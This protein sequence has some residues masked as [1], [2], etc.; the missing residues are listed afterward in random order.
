MRAFTAAAI[1][2][3][4]GS[5]GDGVH[6]LWSPPST[7]GY[8]VGG[9]DIQRRKAQD[10][11]EIVC[12]ALSAAELDALHRLVRLRVPFGEIAVREAACPEFPRL[13]PD[14]PH[15]DPH[16][17]RRTCSRF[18]KLE[19]GRGENPRKEGRLVL[20]V[21]DASGARSP[22]TLVREVSGY[23]GLDCGFQ[24]TIALPRAVTAV[25]LTLV[26]FAAPADVE[27]FNVDGTRA[28]VAR[29]SSPQGQRETLRLTGAALDRIAINASSDEVL[30]LEACFESRRRLRD[31]TPDA[32]SSI[33]L[34]S[35]LPVA[36]M[37]RR[38]I[39][40]AAPV[41]V[42]GTSGRARCLAY[43]IRLPD[44]HSFVEVRAGVPTALAIA[45][46]ESK[47]VDERGL[48]DPFGNQIARFVGRDVD[49][50]LLYTAAIVT[51]LE[52]CLDVPSDPVREEKNWAGEP[53]IAK[54]IQLPIRALD[55][56]LSSEADE[57][58]LAMSRL[59]GSESFDAAA[60]RDVAELLNTAAANANEFSPVWSSTVTRED[61]A[62]P[63]VELR[64]WPYAL[65]LLVDAPWRRM[66]GFGFLDP[67]ANLTPAQAY[68]YRIT[69]RFRRRDVEEKLHGFHSVPRGTTLPNSFALGQVLLSTPGPTTVALRSAIAGSALS[70]TGRK[71]IA[72]TGTPCLK[73]AFS[74]P[75]TRIVLELEPG[76]SLS[77]SASTTDYV[78][79][80]PL[81][82]F[83][84]S[85]PS[86]SRVTIEPGDPF[87]TLVLAGTGF[88]Y[89]VR[90]VRSP[91]GTQPDELATHSVVLP[92]VV[93]EDT[94]VPASP[95]FLGTLNLQQPTAPTD[96][97]A[98]Q[99]E[100][101]ASLGFRLN[102]L[103]PVPAGASGPLPWPADLGAFPHFD[104]LGFHIERRRVDT[105]GA[106]EPLDGTGTSTLVF[107]SRSARRVPPALTPG[108]DL[109]AVYPDASSPT[110]PVPVFMS[111][112]DVLVTADH[113]GPPLGSLH[114]YRIF[115]ADAIGRRSATARLGSVSRLEKRQAP[116]QPVG[117]PTAPPAGAVAPSGVRARAL[118]AVDADIPTA[119][120]TLLGSSQNAVVLEWGWTQVERDRD[121]HATE[122][123]VYWQPVAPDIVTGRLTDSAT[124]AGGLY[125][126]AA[127]LDRPIIADAMRGRY[128][129]APDYPFKVASHTAGQSITVR[130]EP[131]VIDLS[132]TPGSADFEFR[133]VLTGAELRPTAW[134]ERTAVVPI[135]SAES[136]RYVFRDLLTL[137]ATHARVRVWVGVSAADGQTYIPDELPGSA[138]NGGRPGNESSIAAAV[139]ASRFMGR[140]T[141]TVPPPLSAV[142]EFV[143]D[144]PA[145]DAIAIR[146]DLPALLP[147]VSI[148]AGHRVQ[149]ERVGLDAIVACVSARA[150]NRIGATL[151]D[152]TTQSYTLAN[153][154]DQASFL[155]QIRTGTPARVEG[156]FLMDFLL[157]FSA[158]LEPLWRTALPVPVAFGALTD[159]LP[160]KAERYVH[161]IRLADAAGHLSAGAA[162]VP[163]VVRVP[164]LRSPSP[165]RLAVP[166]SVTDMLTVDIRVRDVFDLAWV[167]LFR[168]STD[169][170]ATGNGELSPPAQLLRLPNRRDLYPND[171]LR[172]RLADGRLLAPVTAVN[173]TSG[174]VEPPDRLLSATLTPGHGRRVAL[175]GVA[176]TRDGMPSRFAGP[177]V[178]LTGPTPLV[179]PTLTVSGAA[180]T[181]TARWSALTV[182]ALLALERS[183][184]AGATWQQVSPWLAETVTEYQLPA[185]TGTV[186][187]RT[188][189]RADRGRTSTGPE[190][191]PS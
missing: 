181:D 34:R 182:P 65:A 83:G 57:A 81:N 146:V 189:L 8:S 178:A 9:W 72:L 42:V 80:L 54:G 142:P 30:L 187:Y 60:F 121:P 157:R 59:L 132:R 166:S 40:S 115:S 52:V 62:D 41:A 98:G 153:A 26:H 164:S 143:S 7:A 75:V 150:D 84:G 124:L 154:T 99:P 123:R 28:G 114:Q 70:A 39:D 184:D 85:L 129:A 139:A 17:P 6:L 78:P 145:G 141:F 29:M 170:T 71:G 4:D 185:A 5:D 173:A 156:R 74:E 160:S 191:V 32:S 168:T 151:P 79:G 63:F 112:D 188:V 165:P 48:T 111:V 68:D 137:D 73:I 10:K 148:P 53:F 47:A 176:V 138:S 120:Q 23:R 67:D 46:R 88:F 3:L 140:P 36:R 158:A 12:R 126:I 172:L 144:E 133:P 101:P 2:R 108:I 16:P 171:G 109:E 163:R 113:S 20:E 147:G 45:L 116:P 14:E 69:G 105:S 61:V 94:P 131:S 118:Q 102:W 22:H 56:G 51:A 1:P 95:D 177:V 125:E 21:R 82:T 180:G 155:A 44:G 91:L 186:R 87:D 183:A 50:I 15:G 134:A 66:L 122:F 167:L 128:I 64:S 169:A 161:R 13:P 25:Q 38:L 104:V 107:G 19:L 35:R 55:A 58:S 86:D 152:G 89:G 117:P 100:A 103:P 119:D 18:A 110:P 127:T 179:P 33:G 93:Y 130:L 175:W 49:E 190:V 77:W 92:G 174:T 136:Y 76:S 37:A 11:P 97:S 24:T 43:D 31:A 27:V 96:P 135:T 159:T 162:I 106:F 90:Q 149:L